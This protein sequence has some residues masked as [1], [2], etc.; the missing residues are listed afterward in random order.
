MPVKRNIPGNVATNA[1]APF[2]PFLNGTPVVPDIYWDI[3]S[4]EQ[5]LKWI[6]CNLFRLIDYSNE[7]TDLINAYDKELEKVREYLKNEIAALEAEISKMNE[8]LQNKINS[9]Y[10]EHEAALAKL[11]LM[12]LSLIKLYDKLQDEIEHIV[13]NMKVYDPTKGKFT[14]SIDAN[15]RILQVLATPADEV[16]N[17]TEVGKLTTETLK[18]YKCG[19]LINSSFKRNVEIPY[20]NTTIKTDVNIYKLTKVKLTT[21]K[22]GEAPELVSEVNV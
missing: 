4:N 9:N 1:I 17:C 18:G 21:A 10:E 19:E 12:Y 2:S 7:Q 13:A 11:N 15:R 20:Q 6:C 8:D 14:N 22:L 3:Y 16:L 5:R